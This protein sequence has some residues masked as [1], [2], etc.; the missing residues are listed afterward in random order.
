M[1]MRK[2]FVH[3]SFTNPKHQ[4]NFVRFTFNKE[5]ATAEDAQVIADMFVAEK[6]YAF[7]W[8]EESK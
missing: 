7:V 5:F 6:R 8:V 1:S 4:K 3:G 2:F